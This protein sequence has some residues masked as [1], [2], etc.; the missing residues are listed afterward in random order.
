MPLADPYDP[1]RL[2]AKLDAGA[3]V[4][5]T[6]IAY[7]VEALTAWADRMRARGLFERAKVIVGVV[8]LR[9]AKAAR[10][11]HERLPGVR[12]SRVHDRGPRAGRRRRRATS[13]SAT[14][15]TWCRASGG[16]RGVVGRAPDGHGPR[17]RGRAGRGGGGSVPAPDR[18]LVRR[19]ARRGPRSASYVRS[20]GPMYS[21]AGRITLLSV[22]L[23]AD[24]RR[25]A[26][27]PRRREDR[28][29][30]IRG[31]AEHVVDARGVEVDVR[32]QTL[33]L[34][35]GLLDRLGDLDTNGGRRGARPS[36]GRAA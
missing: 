8:P 31:D 1:Q 30:Q 29:H 12:V 21:D 28:R 26:G 3:D 25:P 15:S 7:D 17:R 2:E 18:R 22:V 5:M 10:F 20:R 34:H 6:Q 13:G 32:V 24:V 27:H 14:R 35:H 33:L 16:S 36:P 4:V 11:M 23:L 19:R 9:S